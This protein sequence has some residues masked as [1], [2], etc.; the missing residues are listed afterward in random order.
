MAAQD[1]SATSSSGS[2][3]PVLAAAGQLNPYSCLACRRQKKKC[4][5]VYPC[6]NCQRK[7]LECVFTAR[8]PSTR[9]RDGPGAVNRVARLEAMVKCL[10]NQVDAASSS[11]ATGDESTGS[12]TEMQSS[13]LQASPSQN[14]SQEPAGELDQ[15]FG[16]LAI[17]E[18]RSRYIAGHSWANIDD[19]VCSFIMSRALKTKSS[20]K[21]I[22]QL[23][24]LESLLYKQPTETAG[25]SSSLLFPSA[26]ADLAELH[27]PGILIPVYWRVYKDNYDRLVKI[28]HVPTTEPLILS[29][30]ASLENLAPSTETLLFAIYFC[31]VITLSPDDCLETFGYSKDELIARYKFAVQQSFTKVNLLETDE[32]IV[33]QAFTIYLTALRLC[34]NLTLLWTL[35]SLLVRLGQNAGLHRDGALF[36]LPPFESEMRRRLWWN[37]RVID[38]RASEDSGYDSVVRPETANTKMPL[39]VD[40]VDLT[41]DMTT[42]PV[43]RTGCTDMVFSIVR[44]EATLA[45]ERLQNIPMG[46]NGL[47][48]KIHVAEALASKAQ[49]IVEYQDRLQQL[50]FAEADPGNP[51]Y[52]YTAIVSRII[53]SKLWLIA[54]HPYIRLD[55]CGGIS[56]ATRDELFS[57]AITIVQSQL[58][59]YNGKPTRTWSWLCVTHVQWYAI[60]YILTELCKR[61]HGD[62]VETAWKAVDSILQYGSKAAGAA[63]QGEADSLLSF[64][65]QL[66]GLQEEEYQPLNK[67]LAA[68]RSAKANA[69]SSD[70]TFLQQQASSRER[71]KAQI[72]DA[73]DALGKSSNGFFVNNSTVGADSATQPQESC[74]E[75][76]HEYILDDQLG[77][78]IDAE[79]STWIHW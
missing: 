45:F 71:N 33:L 21:P 41:P 32:F 26:H 47:C 48:G 38:A 18:G 39:N 53:L 74:L 27:P 22:F 77:S 25:G 15:E 7:K 14:S 8:K 19:K 16:R 6:I 4:D 20:N 51:F 58:L 44:F 11:A 78:H 55:V 76:A 42:L 66:T 46:S 68:A 3:A 79:T 72:H 62:R 37:I 73:V 5:R 67:L 69:L 75:P 52:W 23:D 30:A 60:A 13:R 40:D 2:P 70:E 56:L 35:T 50:V 10:R 1:V 17:A 63:G 61:T 29:A 65:S 64:N 12:D 54:Y 36:H 31:A 34:C 28:L 43:E 59:L 57:K 49:S 9:E 24:D